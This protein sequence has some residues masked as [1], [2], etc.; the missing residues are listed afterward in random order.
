MSGRLS[1]LG[2]EGFHKRTQE[3][4]SLTE[5]QRDNFRHNIFMLFRAKNLEDIDVIDCARALGFTIPNM[6]MSF[7]QSQRLKNRVN[8][9][10]QTFFGSAH[11]EAL[12]HLHKQWLKQEGEK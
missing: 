6:P 2:W 8:A 9:K 10:M 7:G 4:N 3:Q 1:P 11:T 5:I 12:R